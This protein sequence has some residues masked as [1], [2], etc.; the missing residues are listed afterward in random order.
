MIRISRK[1][2]KKITVVLTIPLTPT[3]ITPNQITNPPIN[4]IIPTRGMDTA[5][6]TSRKNW[7]TCQ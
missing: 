4:I 1:I 2:D 3:I 7:S 5:N 6:P